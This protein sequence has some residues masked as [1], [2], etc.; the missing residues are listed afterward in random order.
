VNL[1]SK[2]DFPTPDSP[3]IKIFNVV[4]MSSSIRTKKTQITSSIL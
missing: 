3:M 2:L 4:T 1:R